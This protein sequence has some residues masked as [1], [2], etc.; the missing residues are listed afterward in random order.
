MVSVC[1]AVCLTITATTR[2]Q[3][4]VPP[5]EREKI[6]QAFVQK[7]QAAESYQAELEQRLQLSG[8]REPIESRGNIFFQRPASLAMI[9]TQPPGEYT[10][11]DG[12]DAYVK[13]NKRPLRHQRVDRSKRPS[14][15]DMM[16]LLDLFRHGATNTLEHFDATMVRT[17]GD[18]LV[19][20]TP[21][22]RQPHSPEPTHIENFIS[23]PDNELHEMR[24]HFENNNSITYRF[25][26]PVRNVP[27][28][29]EVFQPR[30]Q[31][32]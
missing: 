8:L 13:K 11:I 25:I 30:D 5:P 14:G 29:R 1:A 28:D 26:D 21:R 7:Q 9:F 31:V 20:L 12:A 17:N 6:I 15:H 23:Q 19:T 3:Q 18:V 27:I 32:K 4:V 16:F 22:Q 24:V 10:I 2:A